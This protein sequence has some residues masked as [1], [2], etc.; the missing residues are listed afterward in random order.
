MCYN[1]HYSNVPCTLKFLLQEKM[2]KNAF[3][4]KSDKF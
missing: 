2:K 1:V 4:K 3:R